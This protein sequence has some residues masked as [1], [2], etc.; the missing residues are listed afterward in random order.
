[1]PEKEQ[2][3]IKQITQLENKLK[4]AK[5]EIIRL[6]K[7]ESEQAIFIAKIKELEREA[8]DFQKKKK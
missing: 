1:M 3:Y 4:I 6:K 7:L 8:L 5:E 2:D